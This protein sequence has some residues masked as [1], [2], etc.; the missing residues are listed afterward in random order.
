MSDIK[1]MS[2]V[3]E[4]KNK[5]ESIDQ[6]LERIVYE[7]LEKIQP[8]TKIRTLDF[9][10]NVIEKIKNTLEINEEL[11]MELRSKVVDILWELQRKGKV[12][13]EDTLIRF[14]KL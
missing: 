4:H 7:E 6:I 5:V 13:F 8:K 11:E 3:P 10:N 14:E 2:K 12:Q 9:V 1:R